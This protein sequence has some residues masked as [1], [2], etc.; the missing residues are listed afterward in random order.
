MTHSSPLWVDP[1][2]CEFVK[3]VPARRN[4]A[5]VFLNSIGAHG[6]SIP[7][8]APADTER[9]LY[10]VQ[11]GVDAETR[12]RLIGSLADEARPSWVTERT[13]GYQ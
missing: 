1:A 6:A 2:E 7:S 10:Q 13:R 4:T 3:D 9:Y 12:Q 5:L 8:D 11:F